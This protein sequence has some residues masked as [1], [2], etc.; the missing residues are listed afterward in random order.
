MIST[1]QER[2]MSQG[3]LK[4]DGGQTAYKLLPAHDTVCLELHW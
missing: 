2:I 1:L 3:E 4:C